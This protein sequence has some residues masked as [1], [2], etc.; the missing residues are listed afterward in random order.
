MQVKAAC[1]C[2]YYRSC[3]LWYSDE[4]TL[5]RVE[6]ATLRVGARAKEGKEGWGGEKKYSIFLSL[7]PSP[8]LLP[9]TCPISFSLLE[10]Q[11]GAFASIKKKKERKLAPRK[12]FPCRLRNLKILQHTKAFNNIQ[13]TLKN[14]LFKIYLQSAF[15]NDCFFLDGFEITWKLKRYVQNGWM[16][17]LNCK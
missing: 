13:S 10:F 15:F 5:G 2:L 4:G 8:R 1:L 11:H 17:Q 9:L 7:S 6:I 14:I 3:R 16:Y 12:R